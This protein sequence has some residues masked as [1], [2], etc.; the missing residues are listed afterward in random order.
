MVRQIND[1]GLSLIKSFEGFRDTAYQDQGG[2]W[3][4][5]YGHT[6]DVTE[7]MTCTM[8]DASN[9]LSA[10]LTNAESGVSRIVTVNLGDNQFAALV[11]FAFNVGLGN[12]A[13]SS[14]VRLLNGGSYDCV[15][16]QLC[17]WDHVN[18]APNAGLFRRRVAEGQL[19]STP[20]DGN[21]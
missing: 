2:I 16:T 7:G 6:A 18:G 21:A 17:R 4:I 20:D 13:N 11:S 3:T 15:P 9:W 14:L 10:D 1:A 8:E 5:G 19:W 12:F